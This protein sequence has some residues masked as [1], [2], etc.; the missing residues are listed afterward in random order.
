[1]GHI[2]LYSRLNRL[3]CLR[4]VTI[5]KR[6]TGYLSQNVAHLRLQQLLGKKYSNS[7]LSNIANHS[8][9]KRKRLECTFCTRQC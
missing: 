3:D 5:L 7:V 4:K 1:M 2:I 8:K 6:L 9:I